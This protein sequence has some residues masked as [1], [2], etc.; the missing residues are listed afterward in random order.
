MSLIIN[1]ICVKILILNIMTKEFGAQYYE[2]VESFIIQYYDCVK[3]LILNIMGLCKE[4]D[5][6]YYDCV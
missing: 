4:H 3:C 1:I 6:Q 2:S 5:P